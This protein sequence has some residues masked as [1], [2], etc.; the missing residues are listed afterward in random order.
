MNKFKPGDQVSFV[1]EKGGGIVISITK[2]GHYK[3]ALEDGFDL[4]VTERELAMV[5]PGGGKSAENRVVESSAEPLKPI[6]EKILSRT[7]NEVNLVLVPAK[8]HQVLTGDLEFYLINTTRYAIHFILSYRKESDHYLI[9]TGTLEPG[10]EKLSGIFSRPDLTDWELLHI[11]LLFFNRPSFSYM[12]SVKKDLPVLLPDVSVSTR[13]KGRFAYARSIEIFRMPEDVELD[14]GLLR[15]KFG[16]TP[17]PE[18][19]SP[20]HIMKKNKKNMDESRYGILHNTK[21]VDLHIECLVKDASSLDNSEMLS[22]QLRHFQKEMDHAIQHHFQSIV[23]I[24]GVGAG[25]LR[26]ALLDELQH[27]KGIS[28]KRGPYEKYGAGAIE[29]VLK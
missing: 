15:D 25:V 26:K 2:N 13:E 18:L 28:W 24:H 8:E 9:D 20:S 17:K 3:V 1:N 5:K 29:V 27:F 14:M 11:Q 7:E 23:F 22:I 21:E 16:E 19:F 12:P 6:V 4:T 10:I